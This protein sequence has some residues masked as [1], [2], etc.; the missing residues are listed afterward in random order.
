MAWTAPPTYVSGNI[1]TAA[2]MNAV[3][4]DLNAL[5]NGRRLGRVTRTT[6]LTVSA[7]TLAGA[8]D[9]FSS[10]LSWTAV[11]ATEYLIEFYVARVVPAAGDYV[12]FN[13][14][15]GSGTGLCQMAI[16]GGTVQMGIRASFSYTP[17]AGT[18]A[19]NIR[20]VKGTSNATI[21]AANGGT[22]I[23]DYAPATL[24]VYG[25]MSTT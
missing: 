2:Q 23:F 1:L 25:P 22:G 8:S 11:A 4:G 19:V 16:A 6:D 20:N 21:Y 12:T 24:T 13:L 17:G 15:D 3:S 18:A 10:D 9:Y 7:T 5:T 14:V